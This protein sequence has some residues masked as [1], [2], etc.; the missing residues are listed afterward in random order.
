MDEISILLFMHGG[1]PIKAQC[2]GAH[3]IAGSY[4]VL[5]EDL[6]CFVR[7]A[8]ILKSFSRVSSSFT[9]EDL[10]AAGVLREGDK[11][12]QQARFGSREGV[13]Q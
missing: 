12:R 8:N 1:G 4:E 6:S 3:L 5:C 2:E 7:V 13:K 9:E 10:V 11:T